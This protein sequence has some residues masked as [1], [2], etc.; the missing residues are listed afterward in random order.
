MK[1]MDVT[2]TVEGLLTEA[3]GQ[4]DSLH[5]QVQTAK[6]E[7]A[8][9]DSRIA[10][11]MNTMLYWRGRADSLRALLEQAKQAPGAAPV[12]ELNLPNETATSLASG[13]E[14]AQPEQPLAVDVSQPPDPC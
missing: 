9:A 6:K 14:P 13:D 7:K 11:L 5:G 10:Q 2:K 12:E 8:Q 3:T 1:D 4:L